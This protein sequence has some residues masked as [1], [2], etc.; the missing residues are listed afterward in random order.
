MK[1]QHKFAT[2]ALENVSV[3]P[4]YYSYGIFQICFFWCFIQ[5]QANGIDLYTTF[6]KMQILEF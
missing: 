2:F 6:W 5:W 4:P 3:S 1:L